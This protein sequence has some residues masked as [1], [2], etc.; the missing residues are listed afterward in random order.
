MELIKK[1]DINKKIKHE[2]QYL[3]S[4]EKEGVYVVI[5]S[6]RAQ[7][8]FQNFKKFISFFN[9]DNLALRI[10]DISFP[11]LSWE[12]GEFDGEASW[13]GNKLKGLRQ[14]NCFVVFLKKGE[15]IFRFIAKGVP[16][17]ESIEIFRIDKNI[18]SLDPS[19]YVIENGN[20]RPW[21]NILN[22]GVGVIAINAVA[23]ANIKINEDDDDLQIIIN[24]IREPNNSPKAHQYWYWCGRILK[25]Q[26]QNFSK[27]VN[28]KPGFNYIEFWADKMPEFKEL[29]IRVT[30]SD[31]IP[32]VDNPLWTGN[33]YDDSEEMI[34]ARLIFGEARSQ[35]REAKI[36]V[37]STVFNRIK[38]PTSTWWPD[39]VHD[40]ILQDQQYESFNQENKN[41]KFIE[42]PY[43]DSTQKES[44]KDCYK[45]A[46]EIVNGSISIQPEVT[47]FHSYTD[48]E[49][50][51]R[52]ET[53][54]V[55]NAKFLKKIGDIYFY[56]SPN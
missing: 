42:N 38:S 7:S 14:I 41:R 36:W 3:F 52:F 13:N 40:V 26:V 5:V 54:I 39:T 10:N 25:G 43:F 18:I 17:L 35:N 28:I 27:T 19:K 32:T 24:G 15:Q 22:S 9:D 11:K 55:S 44:W 6:A 29:K 33:F 48:P 45:V 4:T 46:E 49:D 12:R 51:K 23:S 21:F 1:E 8:W 56:S 30:I 20:R 34:L 53:K 31:R 47:H 16:F 37:A 50:I 2:F